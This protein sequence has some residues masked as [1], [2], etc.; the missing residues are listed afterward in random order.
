PFDALTTKIS[1]SQSYATIPLVIPTYN[2]LMDAIE[3]F[4]SQKNKQEFLPDI[5]HGA[6]AAM[7]KL[8]KYYSKTD[9]SPMNAVAT[10][11]NPRMKFV[12]WVR[13]KWEQHFR[14]QAE[15]TIRKVWSTSYQHDTSDDATQELPPDEA[16]IDDEADIYGNAQV[17]ETNELEEYISARLVKEKMHE[18]WQKHDKAFPHLSRMARDYLAIP[19]TSTPSERCFSQAPTLFYG[20][21]FAGLQDFSAAESRLLDPK[22][23]DERLDYLTKLVFPAISDKSK[24][25]QKQM[26]QKFNRSHH[27][28]E[29][30]VGSHVMIKDEEATSTLDA[31]YAGPFRVVRRTTWGTYVLRD[32]MNQL[33]ARNYAPEQLKLAYR[34]DHDHKAPQSYRVESIVSHRDFEGERLY[35]VK[36][37]GYDETEN[38]EIPYENFDSKSLVTRYYK[39]LNQVNPHASATRSKGG[40]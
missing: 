33:L 5:C 3:D 15:S 14:D 6:D 13:Q 17:P 21:A 37:A 24:V 34:A 7:D 23:L 38:S 28:T 36:W 30:P 16:I 29:F 2:V 32:A 19:A 9:D 22:D 4:G 18:F 25:T 10:A 39:K 40:A 26:I 12:W 11:L 27:I 8:K 31:H 35:M 20:R 1:A